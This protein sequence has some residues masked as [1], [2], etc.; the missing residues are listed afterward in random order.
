MRNRFG[1]RPID[2]VR[3]SLRDAEMLFNRRWLHD[4]HSPAIRRSR[5]AR[6]GTSA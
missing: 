3:A 5:I 2:P 6:S 1:H 4:E